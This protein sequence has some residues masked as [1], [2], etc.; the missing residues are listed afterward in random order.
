[1]SNRLLIFQILLLNKFQLLTDTKVV[2]LSTFEHDYAKIIE[3]AYRWNFEPIGDSLMLQE[4][5][6]REYE[7]K[8]LQDARKARKLIWQRQNLS[9]WFIKVVD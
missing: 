6:Q 9:A 1:M 3:H 2:P 7:K 8:Q 5:K 4:E